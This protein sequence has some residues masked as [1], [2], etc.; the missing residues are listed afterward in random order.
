MITV[1]GS[2]A[3]FK[4]ATSAAIL[5]SLTV[6]AGWTSV[7]RADVGPPVEVKMSMADLPA[8]SGRIFLGTFEV[9]FFEEGRLSDL[10]VFGEGWTVQHLDAPTEPHDI[11]EGML[12]I[13]F[14][15]LPDDAEKSIWI[16]FTFKGRSIR[17]KFEVGQATIEAKK[18]S[19]LATA[20]REPIVTPITWSPGADSIQG[21]ASASA[22]QR[23][24]MD[25][26]VKGQLFYPRAGI[27]KND[28]GDYDDPGE[29]YPQLVGV[30]NVWFNV[31]DIDL[32]GAELMKN[33]QTD[34]DG[35][36]D[37]GTFYWE[38][39]N[40]GCED[41]DIVVSFVLDTGV[42]DVTDNSIYENTIFAATAEYQDFAGG[43]LD[44]GPILIPPGKAP[45]FHIFNS[46]VRT[47]RF[48]RTNTA[49]D[50]PKV[51]VEWPDD[52][53]SGGAWYQDFGAEIHVST[54]RQWRE[55]THAHEFGH[56]FLHNFS[57]TIDTDYCNGICD[58]GFDV[59]CGAG[60]CVGNGG[61]CSWCQENE[62]DAW[63]EGWPNW[64]ADVV[65][66]SLSDDYTFDDGSAYQPLYTRSFESARDCCI[67]NE[68]QDPYATEA[69][70]AMLLRDIEDDNFDD[71][72][73]DGIH[74]SLCMGVDEIFDIVATYNPTN[75]EAFMNYFIFAY[76]GAV[77]RLRHTA[78]NV[79]PILLSRPNWPDDTLPLQPVRFMTSPSHPQGQ[80]SPLPC[81]DAA[82]D[83]PLDDV[84]G[85]CEYSFLC[86][87]SD[88]GPGPSEF[89]NEVS[90]DACSITGTTTVNGVGDNYFHIKG[91]QCFSAAF[92]DEFATFGP[93]EVLDCN[94][95]GIIDLCDTNCHHRGYEGCDLA[96]NY[97][98]VAGC[99]LS[100]D[101]Q[102]NLVPDECDLA[103]GTSE[104]CNSD[105]IPDECEDIGHWGG[106]TGSWHETT[107][108]KETVVPGDGYHICVEEVPEDVTAI[109]AEGTHDIATL[110]CRESLA[111]ES[112]TYPA[113]PAY[114]TVNGGGFVDGNVSIR[115]NY[116]NDSR[117][118]T[119]DTL[120]I[121]GLLT[122]DSGTLMG[123]G[124]VIV[125]GG[126]KVLRGS[127][128][129]NTLLELFGDSE[130]FDRIIGS[131]SVIHNN[132]GATWRILDN[133]INN[134]GFISQTG[135]TLVNDGTIRMQIP[136]RTAIIGCPIENAGE[137]HVDAGTLSLWGATSSTG[138][139]I[140]EPGTVFELSCGNK[141]FLPSS[142][143]DVYTM[144]SNG[145]NCG[146]TN[147]RGTVNIR[148][149][150]A[151]ATAITFT[152]EANIISYGPNVS[153][154]NRITF[155]TIVGGTVHFDSLFASGFL[156][157]NSPDPLDVENLSIIGNGSSGGIMTTGPITV[158]Q[159]FTWNAGATLSGP[160][161]V[162]INGDMVVPPGSSQ[163]TLESKVMNLAGVCTMNG[164]FRMTGTA[165]LNILPTGTI[166]FAADTGISGWISIPVSN[167]GR[168]VKSGGVGISSISSPVTNTG[169]VEVYSGT[170]Q[171]P[172]YN[173]VQTAGETI[174][175]G[176]NLETWNS[177]STP[178]TVDIQGGVLKGY[179]T[180]SADTNNTGGVVAPGLSADDLLIDGHYSQTAP[181]VLEIELGGMS[182]G[183]YD[184]LDV[185]GT[186][187]LGGELR[188]LE[189]DGYVPSDGDAFIVLTA[190]DVVG[191]F[192]SVTTPHPVTVWYLPTHVAISFGAPPTDL[193]L[194]GDR[195]LSDYAIFSRCFSGGGIPPQAGCAAAVTAD[196]D[197][198]N[199]VDVDDYRVLSKAAMS[200]PM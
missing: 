174:L 196:L 119:L 181:G 163:S 42:V 82:W 143:I 152:D 183:F 177:N 44:L 125:N 123:P 200:G 173:Y 131:G 43:E 72:D 73:G 51:Q 109:Y 188:L 147:I 192:D 159:L 40:A 48:I 128:V 27:D 107:S 146:V 157:F 81:F 23:G 52:S 104:D 96:V 185:T 3:R 32:S 17:R 34:V 41:P 14:R 103:D 53:R 182:A 90:T 56:H 58:E 111:V 193:D 165:A 54:Q 68:F 129:E 162:S 35:R 141:E 31:V 62:H 108:W 154:S 2:S 28:D 33:G 21:E 61:H 13:P 89:A 116:V 18:V 197:N 199:D 79:S 29:T 11:K 149:S 38:D 46:I 63:N 91:R 15:A 94:S 85:A 39:C 121:N 78:E 65:T 113:A 24:G 137:L 126:L 4:N 77:A 117:L 124:D 57:L 86:S 45:A 160:G 161:V 64:L 1:E 138:S 6:L 179:G 19:P 47:E 169:T 98:D 76:P 84:A 187:T 87:T 37:T 171:F 164:G 20:L 156:T 194:D 55:E 30:D 99:G 133:S 166:D 16:A 66:R 178:V 127:K 36:F 112:R 189:I 115:V 60:P 7:A 22:V 5:I 130:S 148:S 139:I 190:G 92:P 67:G 75:I 170:L 120:T 106:V 198:D 135:G 184:T 140:G 142:L 132:V 50:P 195:D 59:D 70:V 83:I 114:L 74:D 80:G 122:L 134:N 12:R 105:G 145:G 88:T 136:G 191:G 180:V 155:D 175:N 151:S 167:A 100:S 25:I 9:Q 186:A 26:R 10:E 172:R 49:Y 95:N 144:R 153:T 102:P 110:S 8:L 69:F 158:N 176:G 71:H 118:T 101:C 97:C 168:I 150:L 93:F